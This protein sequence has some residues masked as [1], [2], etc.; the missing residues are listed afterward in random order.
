MIDDIGFI[1]ALFVLVAFSV[2]I[3]Y[4]MWNRKD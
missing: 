1:C 2:E 3:V 4:N